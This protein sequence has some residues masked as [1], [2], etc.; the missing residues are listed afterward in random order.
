MR[1][2]T[3]D[4][5]STNI[6]AV[7]RALNVMELMCQE[8]RLMGV[9]EIASLLGEYQSTIYRVITTL[10]D[11]GYIFQDQE[12]AKYGLGY[13][14]Y[15]L[16][17]SV[18][19]TS[20]LIQLV[21]PHAFQIAKEL[22]ETVNVGIRV[23]DKI[24]QTGYNAITIL[25][26]Q[27]GNRTLRSTESLGKPYPCY[28]SGIGKVLM[29]FSEDYDE[30]I[31]KNISLVQHT[32]KS[33]TDPT[34]YIKEMHKIQKLGYAIDDEENEEGL[35]CIA[36]PVLNRKGIAVMALSVSGFIGHVRELGEKNVI[37][38]LQK[39]CFEISQQIL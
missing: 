21:K 16:G 6:I 29:A 4:K 27:G 7:D 35:Y 37:K 13:K 39:S 36:C 18:E 28:Y 22:K 11:R 12:S 2:A 32:K 25:Q 5:K 10:K 31:I 1:K 8:S 33:I 34:E 20:S 9:N 15:I 14:V 23:P 3:S 19:K 24:S 38:R 26:E 17:K 30:K